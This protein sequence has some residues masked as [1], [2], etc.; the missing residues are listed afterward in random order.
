MLKVESLDKSTWF[1]SKTCALVLIDHQI[2]TMK[3]VKN[4]AYVKN[5]STH[6]HPKMIPPG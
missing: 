2:D 5:A 3:L 4:I 6:L 1:N